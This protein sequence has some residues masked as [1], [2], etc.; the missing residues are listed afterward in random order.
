VERKVP[1]ERKISLVADIKKDI[2]RAEVVIGTDHS[3]LGVSEF[4]ALRRAMMPAEVRVRVVKNSLAALA[5]KEAGR[6]EIAEILKGPTTLTFGF[7][8]PIAPARQLMAHL[9]AASLELPIHGGWMDGKVL[10]ALEIVELAKIPSK[11]DLLA[12]IV[13]K[14]RTPISNLHSLLNATMRD[15]TGLIE[16]RVAQLE[17]T[18]T[19]E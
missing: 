1:A 12:A 16:S 4:Q 8:D 6:P 15:F 13:G 9:N 3:Q 19:E 17:E 2:E 18:T 10:T 14:L 5:A 11:E 7:G